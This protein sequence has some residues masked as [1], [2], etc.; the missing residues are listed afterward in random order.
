MSKAVHAVYTEACKW[1]CPDCGC[2]NDLFLFAGTK[3]P[4]YLEC[5][6]CNHESEHITWYKEE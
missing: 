2:M 4:E 1:K 6:I 3:L 5:S